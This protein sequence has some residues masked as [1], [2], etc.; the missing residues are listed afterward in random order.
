MLRILADGSGAIDCVY[1]LDLEALRLAAPAEATARSWSPWA[2]LD[3]LIA[4][5]RVR[6]YDDLLREVDRIPTDNSA[7]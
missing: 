7:A 2:T 6:D 5:R 4:Q 3:R 1:H